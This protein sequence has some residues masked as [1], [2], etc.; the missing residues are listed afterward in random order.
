MPY[1]FFYRSFVFLP[2][3]QYLSQYHSAKLPIFDGVQNA[4]NTVFFGGMSQ[5][6]MDVSGNLV[7]DDNVPFVKTISKVVRYA[8]GAMDE[9]KL[10]IEMPTLVGAGSEFI[11]I[12]EYFTDDML[13]L[14]SLP[15]E[16]TLVGYIYGGI[17]STAENIFFVNDGIQ[18]SA[19]NVI[20]KV[21]INKATDNSINEKLLKGDNVFNLSIYPNPSTSLLNIEFYNPSETDVDLSIYSVT[22]KL[23]LSKQYKNLNRG[24]IQKE[25]H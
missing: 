25:V 9:I 20:F 19:S 2:I 8:D 18:S 15:A 10:P 14:D 5:Y 23:V 7:Q 1:W 4:M 24:T 22:G 6:T 16:R 12:E 17:E 13:Y 3:S 11:E 21:F